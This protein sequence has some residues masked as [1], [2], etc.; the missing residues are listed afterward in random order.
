M[1]RTSEAKHSIRVSAARTSQKA[2]RLR[3]NV[4]DC[5][6][7][8][9]SSGLQTFEASRQ[10]RITLSTSKLQVIFMSLFTKGKHFQ[11]QMLLSYV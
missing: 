8:G 10:T 3:G 9:S 2:S 4:T 5:C 1:Q 6:P 11:A 7:P